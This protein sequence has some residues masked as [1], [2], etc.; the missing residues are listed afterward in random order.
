MRTS[1]DSYSTGRLTTR[2][3]VPTPQATAAVPGLHSLGLDSEKDGL[4]YIPA[5][6]DPSQPAAL[7]VMLHGSG[8]TPAQGMG[9]LQRFADTHNLII[10]APASR[11]YTWD[12]IV[13]DSFGPDVIYI[14]QALHQVFGNYAINPAKVAVGG[15]SDGASYA[16]CLGLTNG[17]VFT[18][19]IA[20]S[21][22]FGF[23]RE[24]HG[25]PVLFLSHGTRDKVLP[26]DPCARQVHRDLSR[27]GMQVHYL[28]F[29]GEH[30]IPSN[31]SQAAIDWFLH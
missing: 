23:T 31:I 30:E 11:K 28:E 25:A 7:A 22:G 19:V 20:F 21:P 26:I 14:D 16:L 9:L 5:G 12:V 17:D 29:D 27:Q 15:F 10:I 2:Y 1:R 3:G 24:K 8:G 4:L 13:R 18:H 6:Y